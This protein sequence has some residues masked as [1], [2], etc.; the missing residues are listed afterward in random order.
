V[1]QLNN[2]FREIGLISKIGENVKLGQNV[3]LGEIGFGFERDGDGYKI[4]LERRVHDC[5]V[6]L[7]DDVE[8]GSN[9]VVHRG[10][11]RDTVIGEG[12]KIDS[13]VHIAHNVIIGKNCLIVAGTVVGGSCS[14]SDGCFIGEN[15]SIKQGVKITHNVTIGMGSV[16]LKDIDQPNS[17][18]VGNPAHKIADVQKF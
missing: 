4:P 3:S 6:V 12:T 8:I 10:R 16:V 13:L 2:C 18:W 5:V 17:T 11:W 1:S 7:E 14:I 9:S 15:V